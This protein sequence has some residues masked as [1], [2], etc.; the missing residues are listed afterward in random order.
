M[1]IAST[2][3]PARADDGG[4]WLQYWFFYLF[5]NKA[6]LGFGLHEGDWEMV[7]VRLGSDEQPQEMAFA[8]HTHGQRCAWNALTLEGEH[9]PVVV[10]S[11]AARRPPTRS[12]G[13]HSA[14][15]VPDYADGKGPRVAGPRST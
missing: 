3:T 9:R 12:P 14:P 5:N 1:P 2:A 11:R 10:S 6:F 8:Q 7:Q 13:K 4:W 15:V